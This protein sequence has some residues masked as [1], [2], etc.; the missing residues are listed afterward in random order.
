MRAYERLL[1]YVKVW[2]TS[3]DEGT[4]V[5]STERQ[6]DLARKLVLE[7]K[8]LGIEDARVDEKCYVYGTIPASEGCEGKPSL[9]FIAHLDTSPDSSG[10]NVKPQIWENY[11]GGEIRLKNDRVISPEM[12]AHL[13]KLKGLTL[14]TSDGTTLLGADDKAGIAEILTMA[15]RIITDKLP[16]GKICIGFTPDEEIGG[17]AEDLDLAAF[18]ADYGYTVDGGAENE[19]EYE[20]FNT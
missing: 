15:E 1:E 2:T 7:M 17:G 19:I 12:F 13:A 10:E 11:D 9:G 20:N 3:D 5:P 4:T 14:I 18:G 16:H 6:I 8:E